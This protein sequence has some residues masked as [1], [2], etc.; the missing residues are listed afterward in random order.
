MPHPISRT[1]LRATAPA[2]RT[3]L[4]VIAAGCVLLAPAVRA[5]DGYRLWLR[6]VAVHGPWLARYRAA[7]TELIGSDGPS[8]PAQAELLRGLTG[9]LGAAP[10]LANE[11]TRD[12]AIV[13]GTPR[14][15][16]VV[17]SLP[18]HLERV[19]TQ[20]YVIR[21]LAIHG[22]R[23]T[24]IAANSD[25][26]VLYGAFRFL[27]LLQTREPVARLD[28]T[29]RPENPPPRARSLGQPQRHR[30]ARLR[31]RLPLEVA[32]P[33]GTPVTAL[34]GLRA[35]LRLDR[36]QRR[37]ARQRQCQSFHP[38]SAVPAQGRCDRRRTAPLRRPRLP[39]RALQ[40]RR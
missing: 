22:H 31:G 26:G 8:S 33:A 7:A 4:G 29:A 32:E 21:T 17:R 2:L 23:A 27:R 40:R 38:D 18:L 1:S 13:F 10:R 34:H 30:G 11:V 15:S 39:L 19:G 20:G 37:G 9:M 3:L 25:V 35:R 12:G 24:V 28:I 36:H 14:S 16:A 5:D 6:Y